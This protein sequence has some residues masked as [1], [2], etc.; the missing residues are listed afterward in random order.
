MPL[1]KYLKRSYQLLVIHGGRERYINLTQKVPVF[2][3]YFTAFTDRDNRL[4]FRKDI[5]QLDARLAA[6]ILSGNGAY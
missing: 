4:N 1:L 3:A 5:Y 6:M 2:I